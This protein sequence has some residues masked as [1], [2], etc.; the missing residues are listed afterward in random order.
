M[1][2]EQ[3][4][5]GSMFRNEILAALPARE[6]EALRPLLN[7]VTLISGQV[8]HEP[9]NPISDVFFVEA[10]VVSLTANTLDGGQVEVGLTGREGLVGVSVM[11]NSKPVSVHRAFIQVPGFANRMSSGALRTAIKQSP[12]LR[13]R[14]LRSVEMVMVESSQVAACNARH[15][16]PERMARWLLMVRDRLDSDNLPMTQEFLSVMLGVRRS[17]V[18]VAAN[19]LHAAGLI[20]QS[21]GH[22]TIADHAGLAAASCDCY[23]IIR[24]SQDRILGLYDCAHS[25]VRH[26]TRSRDLAPT[27]NAS[28]LKRAI[29][30]AV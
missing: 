11:L 1:I 19:T 14:C 15:N 12:I 23:G 6:I 13:D 18:T 28:Q 26:R 2:I 22:V 24:R 10:G 5:T 30:H 27:S 17:G 7:G 4:P 20:S 9:D 8:L 25:S 21:R 3:G 29:S 16:L